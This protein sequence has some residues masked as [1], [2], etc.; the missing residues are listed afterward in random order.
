MMKIKNVNRK[1]AC[2]VVVENLPS[3]LAIMHTLAIKR[4]A[5]DNKGNGAR[6]RET[7]SEKEPERDGQTGIQ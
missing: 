6:E 5:K 2:F 4:D 7:E 1:R 3:H